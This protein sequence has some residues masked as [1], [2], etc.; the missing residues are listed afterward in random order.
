MNIEEGDVVVCWAF[1]E[2]DK[3]TTRSAIVIKIVGRDVTLLKLTST[4]VNKDHP[5][6]PYCVPI[7]ENL[8]GYK[9][10][11]Y[12]KCSNLQNN[13]SFIYPQITYG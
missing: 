5:I 10:G 3:F 11:E 13:P 2:D 9:E 6:Y 4:K 8:Q 7:G 1:P 12:L